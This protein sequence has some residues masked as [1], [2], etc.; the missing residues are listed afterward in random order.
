R[1]EEMRRTRRPGVR[2]TRLL[3]V[4]GRAVESRRAV[5]RRCRRCP[6]EAGGCLPAAR[7]VVCPCSASLLIG[8]PNR[9]TRPVCCRPLQAGA[10]LAARHPA[11]LAWRDH[12]LRDTGG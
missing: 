3:E 12:T 6:K 7:Q 2:G 9:P 5:E 1:R 10:A 4:E 8:R 11:R